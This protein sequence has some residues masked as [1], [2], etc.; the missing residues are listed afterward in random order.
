[1]RLQ[2]YAHALPE[3]AS[4][5]EWVRASLLTSYQRRLPPEVYD[6][7]VARYRERLLEAIGDGGTSY[8]FT[9]KRL[10]LWADRCAP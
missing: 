9:F 8:L 3:P 10:L 1:V 2:V 5:V 7:F 6:R 4:V